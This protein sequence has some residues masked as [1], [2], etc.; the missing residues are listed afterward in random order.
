QPGRR[1]QLPHRR[2]R[3]LRQRPLA[4]R[5]PKPTP[6]PAARG[7]PA[8]GSARQTARRRYLPRPKTRRAPPTTIAPTPAQRGMLTVSLCL[9][10]SSSE[11]SLAS[12]V[13]LV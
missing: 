2:Q 6:A 1:R 12:F 5:H 4:A 13:S 3:E 8:G 7:L 10:D 9:T 11:P